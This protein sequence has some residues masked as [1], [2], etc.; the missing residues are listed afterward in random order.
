MTVKPK[1]SQSIDSIYCGSQYIYQ[2]PPV[3][4]QVQPSVL[5]APG[6]P[7][8]PLF[9]ALTQIFLMLA[10]PLVSPDVGTVI[11]ISSVA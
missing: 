5:H 11:T 1:A 3:L 4:M 10:L 2:I 6:S 9:K 7:L 8:L